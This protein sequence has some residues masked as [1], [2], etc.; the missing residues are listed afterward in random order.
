MTGEGRGKKKKKKGEK[1]RIRG[2]SVSI[3][4]PACLSLDEGSTGEDGRKEKKKKR[5]T[6]TVH[7]FAMTTTSSIGCSRKKR[8]VERGIGGK[9]AT[10]GE[11]EGK[12]KK[13]ESRGG[14]G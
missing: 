8:G 7:T 5:I 4:S 6:A 2:V 11:E 9:R 3:F 12:K 1:P 14:R 13:K 10:R